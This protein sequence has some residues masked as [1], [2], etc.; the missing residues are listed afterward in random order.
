ME[1]LGFRRLGVVV[2]VV[3]RFQAFVSVRHLWSMEILIVSVLSFVEISSFHRFDVVVGDLVLYGDCGYDGCGVYDSYG[4]PTAVL[5]DDCSSCM[6]S[7]RWLHSAFDNCH[8]SMVSLQQL[9]CLYGGYGGVWFSTAFL[10]CFYGVSVSTAVLSLW[11]L[12]LYGGCVFTA[13]V[14]LWGCMMC[15]ALRRVSMAVVWH[16]S[17]SVVLCVSTA[18]VCNLNQL[19]KNSNEYNVII[20]VGQVPDI[21]AFK[22][23][24][25]IL[26]SRC[27]YFKDKLDAITYNNNVKIIKQPN[28]SIEVFNI[29][30]KYIYCGTISLENINA[31]VIFE[32][33]IASNE[34][35]LEELI[36]HVQS[37]LLENNASWLRLNFSRVYQTSFKDNNLKDLQQFC[38]NIIAKHPN[39][40]FDSDEFLSLPENILIFILKLD[41]LQMDEGK[42]WDYTIKWG[43]AQNPSLPPNHDRWSDEHFSALKSSLQDCLPLIRYFQIPGEDVFNKVKP[44]QKILEPNLWDD[45]MLKFMAPNSPITSRVLPPRV[46]L[47]S[48]LPSR[49]INISIVDNDLSKIESNKAS[50]LRKGGDSY[51]IMGKYTE[52][53]T[54]LTKS[55]EIEPNNAF[56]LRSRGE[57]YRMMGKYNESLADLNKSLE[58]EPNNTFALSGRGESYRLMGKY[59]ESVADLNKS[60]EIEPNNAFA[61]RSRGESYRMMDKNNESLADLNKSLEIEPNNAFAL[62]YRGATYRMMSRYNESLADLNKSLEID[63]NDAFVLKNRGDSYRLMGR[64]NESLADLNKSS[65]IKSNDSF[66]LA[67]RGVTYRLMGKYEESLADLNKSL[68]INPDDSWTLKEREKTNRD[69]YEFQNSAFQNDTHPILWFQQQLEYQ[70][71]KRNLF[72]LFDDGSLL[73]PLDAYAIVNYKQLINN[74]INH[75]KRAMVIIFASFGVKFCPNI[76]Q[77]V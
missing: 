37:F 4:V 6:V 13:V 20:E 1:I 75:L 27:L 51:R 73:S 2:Y 77:V 68:E 36:K 11:R 58:I 28:I 17:T 38:A 65:E 60:L 15:D 48:T 30:I 26:N 61:L 66:T 71:K 56:A 34:F 10:W 63:P 46:N 22:V 12:C 47:P 49:D 39:I 72:I 76:V 5:Y 14:S 33:L 8:V 55:L 35:R 18:V 21:Q 64:Y 44:Y 3:W 70:I 69:M 23:H 43:I 74:L 45:I 54:D 9:W 31:S 57:S 50:E 41:N 67:F 32:L 16:V 53:I 42:I 25:I 24:S 40:I 7:L 29:I 19:L 62:G 52:S 59:N